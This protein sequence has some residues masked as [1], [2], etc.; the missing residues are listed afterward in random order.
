MWRVW[1]PKVDTMTRCT[2][3][4]VAISFVWGNAGK[5]PRGLIRHSWV[6]VLGQDSYLE[7]YSVLIKKIAALSR[8]GPRGCSASSR[9]NVRLRTQGSLDPWGRVGFS[10]GVVGWALARG[11]PGIASILPTR[12]T[13]QKARCLVPAVGW[14]R[15]E[16]AWPPREASL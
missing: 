4:I 16:A 7:S 6:L 3:Y 12:V 10:A 9:G 8:M 1:E 5:D 14:L 11:M 15:K 2:L 13:V